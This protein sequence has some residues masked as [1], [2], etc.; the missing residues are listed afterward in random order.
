M[1]LRLISL[2]PLVTFEIVHALGL[3]GRAV[4]I[5]LRGILGKHINFIIQD[6]AHNLINK[7]EYQINN[8]ITLEGELHVNGIR[9]LLSG[10]AF[11]DPT[12][13]L[14]FFSFYLDLTYL[15]HRLTKEN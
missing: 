1:V 5:L 12:K 10:S 13:K 4:K 8:Q 14:Y 7:K 3:R 2:C 11:V 9:Y 15:K 6:S